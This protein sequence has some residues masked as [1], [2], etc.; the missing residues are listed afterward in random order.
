MNARES[1]VGVVVGVAV[2]VVGFGLLGLG[3]STHAVDIVL[4]VG[5]LVLLGAM[6]YRRM[7]ETG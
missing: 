5:G 2:A 1:V 7:R 6:L 4:I 3:Y